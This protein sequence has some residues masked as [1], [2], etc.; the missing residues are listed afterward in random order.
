MAF[1]KQNK[2]SDKLGFSEQTPEAV[3]PTAEV[4]VKQEE[5]HKEAPSNNN[6]NPEYNTVAL[7]LIKGPKGYWQVIE[8]QLDSNN[9]IAGDVK[10]IYEEMSKS[11][12]LETFKINVARKLLL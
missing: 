2:K 6:N 9:L 8:V 1:Q 12:V 4:E 5:I 10:V 3:V 7:S 11:V